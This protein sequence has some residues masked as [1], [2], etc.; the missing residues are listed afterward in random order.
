MDRSETER[1]DRQALDFEL[2]FD[3]EH[4][5]LL[6]RFGRSLSD[7]A[8][9]NMQDAVQGFVQSRGRCPLIIDLSPVEAI[10]VSTQFLAALGRRKAVMYGERRFIV[11]PGAE[12]YGLARMFEMHQGTATGDEPVVLRSLEAAYQALGISEPGFAPVGPG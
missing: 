9:A 8:I 3:S 1:P 11:A 5:V 4:R 2:L 10:E 12:I 6:V 7:G